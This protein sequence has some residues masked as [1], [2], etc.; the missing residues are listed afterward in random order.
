MTNQ[1]A[2]FPDHDMG[3]DC[4]IGTNDRA[5]ANHG[6]VLNPRGGIDRAHQIVRQPAQDLRIRLIFQWLACDANAVQ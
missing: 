4:A 6:A 2:V 1:P 3:T 5:L